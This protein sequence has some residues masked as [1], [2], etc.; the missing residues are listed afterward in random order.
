MNDLLMRQILEQ[1]GASQ[2]P[3][4]GLPMQSPDPNLAIKGKKKNLL[5]D[6]L[7]GA[8]D[9]H[10]DIWNQLAKYYNQPSV[11]QKYGNY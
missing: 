3:N 7:S 11:V 9:E 10:T 5:A 1:Y 2:K 6:M 4:S 8:T